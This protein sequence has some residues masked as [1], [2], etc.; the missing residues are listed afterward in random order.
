MRTISRRFRWVVAIMLAGAVG[1][2]PSC[3][4][5]GGSGMK[6]MVDPAGAS[7]RAAAS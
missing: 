7:D 1:S 2:L 5:M 4:S 3:A 6:Y